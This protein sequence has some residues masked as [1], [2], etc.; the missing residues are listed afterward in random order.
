MSRQNRQAELRK[1]MA[2]ARS[3]L[4]MSKGEDSSNNK[5][6]IQ[7]KP[8][9]TSGI[10]R[11]PKYALTKSDPKLDVSIDHSD[12]N[13]LGSLISGYS[14]SDDED[15]SASQH[16]VAATSPSEKL[17]ASV[18]S[19]KHDTKKRATLSVP[20]G[21]PCANVADNHTDS[22]TSAEKVQ[23]AGSSK[24]I[25]A[26]KTVSDEVWDEFNALLEDEPDIS[27]TGES[28]VDLQRVA[29]ADITESVERS[30]A[31][32]TEAAIPDA[33]KSK[34]KKRKKNQRIESHD[35]ETIT[36]VE[37]LSYEARLARLVLL[38]G[39]M[40]KSKTEAKD[41]NDNTLGSVDFYDTGLAF[42]QD[43]DG[44]AD[45]EENVK[46]DASEVANTSTQTSLPGTS[47]LS[48]VKILKRRRE[49]KRQLSS[50]GEDVDEPKQSDNAI[51]DGH[52]F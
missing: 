1:R 11:K 22:K 51:A 32:D 24:Q 26:G 49:E 40:Q 29:S 36:N 31:Y 43:D 27:E 44:G 18:S 47:R 5:E 23:R 37:Q 10:L 35:T 12:G 14:S 21:E 33:V 17:E 16:T 34:K 45:H 13:A 4:Q 30:I 8:P 6:Q 20:I 48:L 46:V 19:V 9:P 50:R 3:K 38:K 42:Q 25:I 15:G 39:K 41:A 7:I 2:E 28:T 52:W